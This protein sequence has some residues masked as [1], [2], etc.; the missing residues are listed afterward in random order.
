MIGGKL[1]RSPNITT[2]MSYVPNA[3]LRLQSVSSA[4]SGI[5]T[6]RVTVNLHG[7]M[8]THVQRAH[9]IVRGKGGNC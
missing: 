7:S 3:G 9:V 4:D 5:Y 2:Q 1:F 6:A 8:E